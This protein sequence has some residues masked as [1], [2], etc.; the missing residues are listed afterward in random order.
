MW[1]VP[2][3]VSQRTACPAPSQRGVA[4][5]RCWPGRAASP[6]GS[7]AVAAVGRLAPDVCSPG[8]RR[9]TL[10]SPVVTEPLLVAHCVAASSVRSLRV[11]QGW[12]H[13]RSAQRLPSRTIR[14]LARS[15]QRT[16]QSLSAEGGTGHPPRDRRLHQ[17]VQCQCRRTGVAGPQLSSTVRRLH[18]WWIDD[19]AI[20]TPNYCGISP[21]VS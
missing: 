10:R 21:L 14:S 15:N 11:E 9:G 17:D 8:C 18:A 12:D 13:R 5:Y 16:N 19:V 6:L 1:L 3:C 2:N 7:S 4:D 20:N